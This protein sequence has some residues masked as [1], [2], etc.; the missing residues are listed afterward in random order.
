MPRQLPADCL[1]E[2]F[3][4]LE[5]DKVTLHSCIL[6]NRL[7]CE[8]SIR[9][10]WRNV[11]SFHR[12]DVPSQILQTLIGCLPNESKDLLYRNGIFITTSAWKPS[13]FNYVS[14]C[15]ILSIHKIDLM[16]RQALG[17]QQ[18]IIS[19]H[20]ILQEI[21]KMFMK[22]IS[23]LKSL[24]YDYDLGISNPAQNV[25]FTDFPGA[26]RCLNNL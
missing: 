18:S 14:F 11:W 19:Q 23:S 22:Q 6:V 3:E 26:K 7:W 5:E 2:I 17:K 20:L 1:N 8:V 4:Y 25:L 15:K 13:L 24:N 12:L 16:I 9:I 10:L 21:L